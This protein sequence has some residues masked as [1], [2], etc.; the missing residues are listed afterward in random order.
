MRWRHVG[1]AVA[2]VA[3]VGIGGAWAAIAAMSGSSL[4]ADDRAVVEEVENESHSETA[5]ATRFVEENVAVLLSADVAGEVDGGDLAALF[6]VALDGDGTDGVFETIVFA[7]AEEGAIHSPELRPVLGE[8]AGARLAWF[9]ARINAFTS[10]NS[11]Q[12]SEL[13]VAYRSAFALLR[14]TMRDHAVAE[15][16][17]Q[18]MTDYGRAEVAA[19]PEAGEERSF[20]LKG[21]GRFQA[22]FTL[23][24]YEAEKRDA[25]LDGDL[26]AVDAAEEADQKR[27]QEDFVG[28]AMWVAV[29]RFESDPA[30][31]AAAVGEPFADA[32]GA[33][34]GDLSESETQALEAWATNQAREGGLLVDDVTRLNA[35]AEDARG[36]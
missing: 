17:R 7:V 12:W 24:Y 4:D 13:R 20:R 21:M 3:V 23:A 30:V 31:R 33:L 26:D 10:D 25:R 14:E 28:R 35:G 34:K 16:L 5:D 9:D 22:F 36:G 27:R 6:E 8:A 15:R 1:F 32:S 19:A 18:S 29:D 11:D 2:A